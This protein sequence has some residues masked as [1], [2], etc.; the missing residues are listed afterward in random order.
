MRLYRPRTVAVAAQWPG[1]TNTGVPSGTSLTP[2]SGNFDTT[3]NGQ[4]VQDLDIAGAL[5]INHS[6]VIVRRCR[7]IMPTTETGA[8]FIANTASGT[9]VVQD[10]EFNGQNK[11]GC[12]G[13]FY[14]DN[15]SPPAVTARR[16]NIH[17]VENGVGCLS[18]FDMR[19]SWVHDLNPGGADPH[20]DGL[21]T[22]TGVSNVNIIHN[23]FDMSATT[24][25][26][27]NSCLQFNNNDTSNQNWLV[28]NNKFLLHPTLGGACVRMPISDASANNL[29]VRNNRMKP[30]TFGYCIPDPPN[31][32]TEWSGN[33]ND[34]TGAAVP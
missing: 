3:S 1:P 27:T 32:I 11:A 21:Q 16:L 24:A 13:I 19:D 6:N 15:A 10:S 17:S 28:E 18:G 9:L 29:R 23:V 7:V 34:T 25:S 5:V 30:G 14:D 20:T 4:V 22:S 12:S 8:L 33:V 2:F 26:G 31:T